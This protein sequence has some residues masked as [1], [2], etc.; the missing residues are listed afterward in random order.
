LSMLERYETN[1]VWEPIVAPQLDAYM[2]LEFERIAV[3]AYDRKH[4]QHGL[5]LVKQWGRWEGND[6]A[7]RSV[8]IDIV[9]RLEDN[10]MMTG[11]ITWG[12]EQVRPGVHHAH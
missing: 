2:G 7:R 6:R 12:S 4:A 10:R 5:P 11:A 1:E 8:E 9:A 3:Q